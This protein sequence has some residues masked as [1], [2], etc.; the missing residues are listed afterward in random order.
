MTGMIQAIWLIVIRARSVARHC[1]RQDFEGY[2]STAA[3]VTVR[4]GGGKTELYTMRFSNDNEGDGVANR[5]TTKVRLWNGK[6]AQSVFL[7]QA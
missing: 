5:G 4:S 3:G 6:V 1:R 7:E 2:A